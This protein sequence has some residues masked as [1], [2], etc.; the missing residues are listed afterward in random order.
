L[1]PLG[2]EHVAPLV[3]AANQGRQNYQFATVP[4]DEEGMRAYVATALDEASRGAGVPF[5]VLR[6]DGEVVGCT[7]YLALEWWTFPAAPPPPVPS[8]PDALEI[9]FTWYAATAQRTAINTASK[10]LLCTH[11][12]EVWGVRRIT[13]KT[14]E[15]N[16]R[17]RAAIS[18]L[19][20]KFD[21]VLR[22]HR[23]ATDGLVRNTAFFSMLQSEWPAAKTELEARLRGPRQD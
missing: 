8:G 9:G 2:P 4:R 6:P 22:A 17:S 1:V 7:R 23:P 12:F 13:W 18:R 5:A 15:R 3:I 10:L 14:D 20:A 11:A 19:G 16:E 21:G